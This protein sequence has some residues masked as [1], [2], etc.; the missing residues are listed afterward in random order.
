MRNIFGVLNRYFQKFCYKEE[1]NCVLLDGYIYKS[2][3]IENLISYVELWIKYYFY[4]L[5]ILVVIYNYLYWILKSG[6]V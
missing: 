3:F 6:G 5:Y 2:F 4:V 1:F